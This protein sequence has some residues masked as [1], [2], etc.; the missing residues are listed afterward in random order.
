MDR[1]RLGTSGTATGVGHIHV[2]DALDDVV[3]AGADIGDVLTFNGVGWIPVTPGDRV[4]TSI[5]A[6]TF[7][8]WVKQVIAVR[9]TDMPYTPTFISEVIPDSLTCS[10]NGIIVDPTFP[11]DIFAGIGSDPWTVILQYSTPPVVTVVPQISDWTLNGAAHAVDG[12]VYLTDDI[13]GLTGSAVCGTEFVNP[14]TLTVTCYTDGE[15]TD[16]GFGFAVL[17]ADLHTVAYLGEV[18]YGVISPYVGWEAVIASD[19]TG[20]MWTQ[21]VSAVD[22]SVAWGSGGTENLMVIT[23][24]RTAPHIASVTVHQNGYLILSHTTVW[25]P[26]NI[27][28]AVGASNSDVTSTPANH[29]I[30]NIAVSAA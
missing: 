22:G 20:H 9:D 28:V 18:A 29:I 6:A 1:G 3:T 19:S 15:G 17:D 4:D 26:T 25:F 16:G 7:P 21:N 11:A 8:T 27:Y 2:L 13:A 14:T 30:R 23:W 24:I 12:D 5:S 10:V